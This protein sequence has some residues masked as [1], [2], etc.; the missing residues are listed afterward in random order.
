[1][2][3]ASSFPFS[4]NQVMNPDLS[5]LYPVN[6]RKYYFFNIYFNIILSSKLTSSTYYS[7]S[8]YSSYQGDQIEQE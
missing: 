8:H 3:Q 4:Q 1:M 7:R 5:Q 2:E 6:V